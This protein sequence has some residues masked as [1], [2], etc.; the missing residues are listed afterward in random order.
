MESGAG[1]GVKTF[2]IPTFESKKQEK[3]A[4]FA[5]GATSGEFIGLTPTA[6]ARKVSEFRNAR[7]ESD[8]RVYGID[9][10]NSIY[11]CLVR[12]HG[13]CM[14]HEEPLELIDLD[15]VRVVEHATRATGHIHFTDGANV[16]IFNISK[17]TLFKQFDM[18]VGENSGILRVEIVERI[19]ESLMEKNLERVLDG[20]I[21][22]ATPA[23]TSAE[24][25][26]E[27]G[28]FVV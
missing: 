12:S 15:A 2:V 24:D 18:T 11:H 14:V 26:A 23:A 1:V 6:L 10:D 4:E 7:V 16:Y 27:A 20:L 8:A 28:K 22:R 5:K 25:V 17:N 19:F 3:I 13:T 9:L 21:V